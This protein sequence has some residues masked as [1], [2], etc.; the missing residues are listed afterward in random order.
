VQHAP[1]GEQRETAR[2]AEA[3]ARERTRALLAVGGKRTADSIHRELGQ[4]MWNQCGM[5]RNA[6]GLE[7]AIKADKV[8]IS[9][10]NTF[11]GGSG[12]DL[13]TNNGVPLSCPLTPR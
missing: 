1:F 6:K 13:C 10:L 5:A 12:H 11:R 4:L 8:F 9:G 3:Q 7:G 2:D